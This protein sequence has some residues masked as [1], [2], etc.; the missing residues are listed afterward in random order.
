MDLGFVGGDE[1]NAIAKKRLQA[2]LSWYFI[3]G[4]LIA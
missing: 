4:E 2:T 1:P 3:L